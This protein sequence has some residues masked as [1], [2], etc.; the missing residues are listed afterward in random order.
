MTD[1]RLCGAE[2]AF[3]AKGFFFTC[4]ASCRARTSADHCKA[5]PR[6]HRSATTTGP[7][8]GRPG[9]PTQR[10]QAPALQPQVQHCS[11]R[12]PGGGPSG[13]A[14]GGKPCS[15]HPACSSPRAPQPKPQC[16]PVSAGATAAKIHRSQ[17]GGRPGDQR[18]AWDRQHPECT[19]GS[20]DQIQREETPELGVIPLHHHG[21]SLKYITGGRGRIRST[22][23]FVQL[24]IPR[25]S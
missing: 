22:A 15:S 11:H 9:Q 1:P 12:G 7:P 23:V 18:A 25:K 4:L 13:S 8:A 16:L 10:T 5:T 21:L 19:G 20:G 3:K 17:P 14:S 6:L 24:S 2:S